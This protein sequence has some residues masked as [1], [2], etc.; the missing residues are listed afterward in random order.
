MAGTIEGISELIAQGKD[1]KWHNFASM[2]DDDFPNAY[3]EEW[4]VWVHRINELLPQIGQSPIGKSIGQGLQ[5]DLLGMGEDSF[6]AAKNLIMNGLMAAQRI[7]GAPI[8]ASDRIVSLGHNSPEQKQ[9]LEKVDELISAVQEANDFPGD[10]ETKQQIVAE[11]SA[12]R[13]I[14]EAAKVRV[15]AL[16]ATLGPPLKWLLEKAAGSITGK[17]A[18]AA[19]DFFAGLHWL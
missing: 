2:S 7:F 10:E 11:L 13:R 5:M 16:S 4:L 15:S 8:P 6:D 18:S 12:A 1:L 14:L 3:S 17:A 19:W 9:A